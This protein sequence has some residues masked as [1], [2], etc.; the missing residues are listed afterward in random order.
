MKREDKDLDLHVTIH[1][2]HYV[3]IATPYMAR[4]IRDMSGLVSGTSG[5]KAR[6]ATDLIWEAFVDERA[7]GTPPLMLWDGEDSDG[8]LLFKGE[9]TPNED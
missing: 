9:L 3:I 7:D 5:M 6:D 8:P 2:G 4:V 1:G